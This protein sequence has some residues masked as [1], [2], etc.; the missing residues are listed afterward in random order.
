MSLAT[1]FSYKQFRVIVTAASK[2][3]P[4]KALN[5]SRDPL[6]ALLLAFDIKPAYPLPGMIKRKKSK[7]IREVIL[8]NFWRLVLLSIHGGY[9]VCK[10]ILQMGIFFDELGK[11]DLKIVM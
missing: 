9:T 1:L 11:F 6:K 8:G 3:S 10:L 2:F 7:R 5:N 4:S